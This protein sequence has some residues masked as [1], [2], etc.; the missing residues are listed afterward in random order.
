MIDFGFGVTLRRIRE[1][2]LETL[3]K[4]RNDPAI[5]KWC[6]QNDV[7]SWESHLRWFKRQDLDATI[8]MYVI[9]AD[10]KLVGVCG[11]TSIDR[12]NSRAEFSLYI[13]PARQGIGLG[14][15]SLKTLISHG[16]MNHGLNCIWGESFEGNPAAKMFES[17]G[18]TK[19]GVLRD[20]YFRSGRF[21]DCVRHSILRIDWDSCLQ[22]READSAT[23]WY[24]TSKPCEG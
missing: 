7:L 10:D 22:S 5:F 4:W 14:S 19:E 16:F 13:D 15:S 9:V 6:R 1:Q 17:V 18:M 20:Y 24:G 12:L 23:P 8:E 2:D 11:L 21:I 3:F